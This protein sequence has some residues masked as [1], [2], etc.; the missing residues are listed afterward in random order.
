MA[1]KPFITNLLGLD[2]TPEVGGLL[3][4]YARGTTTPRPLYSDAGTTPLENPVEA[5]SLGQ[6]TAYF[7]DALQYSWQAKT[8]DRATILWEA[9][10]VGGILSLTYINPDYSVHPII[11]AS[12]VPALG[13][14]LDPTWLALFQIDASGSFVTVG[15]NDQV[16]TGR[17][18]AAAKW[19]F[20][21]DD[22]DF[23]DV[24]PDVPGGKALSVTETSTATADSNNYLQQNYYV[25][26]PGSHQAV[27][28]D[29]RTARFETESRGNFNI[30]E[31]IGGSFYN[32]HRG[33]GSLDTAYG[34]TNQFFN[35]SVGE[36]TTAYGSQGAVWNNGEGLIETGYG[37]FFV[38]ASY[39]SNASDSAFTEAYGAWGE[40]SQ[41]GTGSIFDAKGVQGLVRISE[42][43]GITAGTAV[44]ARI[45]ILNSGGTM[46]A[47]YGVRTGIVNNGAL[48]NGYGVFIGNR[49]GNAPSGDSFGLYGQQDIANHLRGWLLIGQDSL[50]QTGSRVVID[51]SGDTYGLTVLKADNDANGAVVRLLH[52]SASPAT[53]DSIGSIQ[54]SAKDS[55]GN[56]DVYAQTV[57]IL[58]DATSTSEDA[59]LES[60]TRRAGTLAS[61]SRV[62]S[63]LVVGA[64]GTQDIDL[65]WVSVENGVQ[66][67]GSGWR[68]LSGGRTRFYRGTLGDD[69]I[70]AFTVNANLGGIVDFM[71]AS[72]ANGARMRFDT[73]GT[74]DLVID[75]ERETFAPF[76]V[77]TGA[78]TGTT[79]ADGAITMSIDTTTLYVENRAGS[80]ITYG[81]LIYD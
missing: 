38:A 65:G 67:G 45:E 28:C 13:S 16:I 18:R 17:K 21:D 56:T 54:Y 52:E 20:G 75:T 69:A 33:G 39:R 43:G 74:S 47:A 53:N 57:A 66:V 11:E 59:T 35:I 41:R 72:V 24:N 26:N 8:A 29:H 80:T 31:T 30:F 49:T 1:W 81:L 42:A 68:Q 3:Q 62:G 27:G 12:W 51:H 79:G 55:A 61:R 2:G 78:L 76:S 22:D 5:D 44:N 73:A 25:V 19:K 50:S 70:V 40:V 36:V 46:G 64:P 63:G 71:I 15:T 58:E 9:D 14:P 34:G 10:V 4:S 60:Y 32:F 77:T 23:S 48:V 37:G 6:I 7:N